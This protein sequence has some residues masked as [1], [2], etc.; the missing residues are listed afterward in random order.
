[1]Q[2]NAFI[3]ENKQEIEQED[4]IKEDYEKAKNN[5]TEVKN[6]FPAAL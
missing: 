3:E 6:L 5:L 2:L 4:S 1:M